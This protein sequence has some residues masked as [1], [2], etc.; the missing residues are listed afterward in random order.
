MALHHFYN[1]SGSRSHNPGPLPIPVC[2]FNWL[3]RQQA[4]LETN[5]QTFHL[6]DR[7]GTAPKFHAFLVYMV[8]SRVIKTTGKSQ[9]QASKHTTFDKRSMVVQKCSDLC[10]NASFFTFCVTWLPRQ[11]CNCVNCHCI[12]SHIQLEVAVS[13]MIP[14]L[15][16]FAHRLWENECKTSCNANCSKLTNSSMFTCCNTN[17]HFHNVSSGQVI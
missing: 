15:L 2:P 5:L 9:T 6:Q 11:F 16:R 4:N 1:S 3:R 17:A 13:D 12:H 14:L 10:P 8:C 7:P